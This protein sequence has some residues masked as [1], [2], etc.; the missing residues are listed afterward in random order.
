MDKYMYKN[1]PLGKSYTEAVKSSSS[2]PSPTMGSST[3]EDVIARRYKS[4]LLGFFDESKPNIIAQG[5]VTYDRV[6]NKVKFQATLTAYDRRVGQPRAKRVESLNTASDWFELGSPKET[7][8]FGNALAKMNRGQQLSDEQLKKVIQE[9][10]K[11]FNTIKK[12]YEESTA[13]DYPG[14]P[15]DNPLG[16]E[17]KPIPIPSPNKGKKIV[18]EGKFI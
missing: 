13:G 3:D 17:P 15:D 18:G 5:S 2:T 16:P 7:A 11:A 9:N 12:F 10:E 14:M 4:S 6:R 8:T 1:T